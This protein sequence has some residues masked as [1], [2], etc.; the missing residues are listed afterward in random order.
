M[1]EKVFVGAEEFYLDSF[2][3][4]RK[5]WDS[6]FRPDF[7][8]GLWRGGTPA[9]IVI[10][11]FFK[12]KGVGMDHIA[13][14]TERYSGIDEKVDEVRVHGLGYV[15]DNVKNTDRLLIVDDVLDEGRTMEFLIEE[16]KNRARANSPR[17][18]KVAVVHYKPNR[19]KSN[20]KP[21]YFIHEDNSWVVFPHEIEGLSDEE[22]LMKNPE[23]A[24]IVKD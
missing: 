8:V 4:A 1:A 15:I 3:L 9:G 12:Y 24:R 16:I 21:D 18:I 23:I 20:V 11:E 22:M 6:G 10:Q 17:E 7:L 2:R 14:R 13:V 5:V 19:N